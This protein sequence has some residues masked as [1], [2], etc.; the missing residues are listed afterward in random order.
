M[1]RYQVLQEH[2]KSLILNAIRESKGAVKKS[3]IAEIC[4][5]KSPAWVSNLIKPLN[6]GGTKSISN[7]DANKIEGLLGISLLSNDHADSIDDIA[8]LDQDVKDINKHLVSLYKRMDAN[9]YELPFIPTDDIIALGELC[10]SM[11]K[12]DPD[13]PGKIG[14]VII[15]KINE[16][17][18][19]LKENGQ[20][21][22]RP[23]SEDKHI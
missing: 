14:R 17:T 16:L 19:I 3:D 6:H 22:L 21:P 23:E 4:G 7:E 5:G 15:E 13:K 1:S 10:L 18:K 12:S 2:H 9:K 20:M 8:M 11:A